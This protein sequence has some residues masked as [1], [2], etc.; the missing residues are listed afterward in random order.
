MGGDFLPLP[1]SMGL[2]SY[3][4][5]RKFIARSAFRT[6]R[7]VDTGANRQRFDLYAGNHPQKGREALLPSNCRTC[8]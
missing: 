3:A 1:Q 7:S 2:K 4:N 5:E 8:L 6:S